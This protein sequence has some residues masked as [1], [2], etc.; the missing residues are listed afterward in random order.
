MAYDPKLI[1]K[2]F[3][4]QMTDIKKTIPVEYNAFIHEKEAILKSNRLPE[5]TKWLMMLVSSVSQK[6]PVC[7]TRAVKHCLEQ[8]WTREEMLEACMVA[9]LVGGASAM[10]YVTMVNQA[11]DELADQ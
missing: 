6:C 10:T 2:N 4:K 3:N 5:K 8:G 9:V 7:V 11:V 1:L